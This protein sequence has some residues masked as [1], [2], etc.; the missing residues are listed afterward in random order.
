MNNSVLDQYQSV[1][2]YR[3]RKAPWNYKEEDELK[4]SRLAANIK[5]NGQVVNLIVRE[6]KEKGPDGLPLLEV[7]DGNHRLDALVAAEVENAVVVNLRNISL[8][9]AKRL[10]IEVNETRFA[11]DEYRIA[12]V[13]A[14]LEAEF[15]KDDLLE[16]LPYTEGQLDDLLSVAAF[17]FDEFNGEP[18]EPTDGGAGAGSGADDEDW[19]EFTVKM[20]RSAFH[21]YLQAQEIV[22]GERTLHS[23][24]AV[25][26][27]QVIEALAAE[28]LAQ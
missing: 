26:H 12:N 10:S 15:G 6:L 7:V 11:T 14:E 8:A 16:T 1:P 5:R 22:Q 27:G 3:L 9:A 21:V 28:L 25:A 20:P 13:L 4:A 19:E 2:V 23:D 17:D 18:P 24:P